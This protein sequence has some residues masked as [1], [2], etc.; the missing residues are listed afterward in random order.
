MWRTV[1]LSLIMT[2]CYTDPV[3]QFNN[4]E[5]QDLSCYNKY[6]GRWGYCDKGVVK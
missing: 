2:S 3:R 5:K 6:G 1:I 4:D